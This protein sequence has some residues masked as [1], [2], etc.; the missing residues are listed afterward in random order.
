MRLVRFAPLTV[1]FLLMAWSV[2]GTPSAAQSLATARRSAEITAFGGY[3]VSHPDYGGTSYNGETVGANF[4]LFNRWW[5]DPSLEARFSH[6]SNPIISENSFLVGPRIQK[7]YGRFHPYAEALFGVGVISY[8]PPPSF[9]PNDNQDSGRNISFG[10]G[11]DF[12]VTRNFSA[13]VDF[14]EQNWNL[15]KNPP[16]QPDGSDYTLAP[17]LL[18]FG[19]TYHLPFWGLRKQKYL[20]Q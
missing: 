13:K 15:G 4:T 5:V 10:G 16:F 14:Q 20:A 8:H 3:T 1:C 19:V 17:S 18:T 11:V 2:E 9:S 12:D 6:S 7:D